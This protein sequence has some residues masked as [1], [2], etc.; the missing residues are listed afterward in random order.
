MYLY[1]KLPIDVEQKAG[2][3]LHD[4]DDKKKRLSSLS[5]RGGERLIVHIVQVTSRQRKISFW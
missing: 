1:S 5:E 3:P 2:A 4:W